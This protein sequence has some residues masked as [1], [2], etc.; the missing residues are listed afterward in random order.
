MR[1]W[2]GVT[3]QLW[4][5]QNYPAVTSDQMN[6]WDSN[7]EGAA[8]GDVPLGAAV[9][10]VCHWGYTGLWVCWAVP[11]PETQRLPVPVL[12]W[13]LHHATSASG[14]SGDNRLGPGGQAWPQGEQS[15]GSLRETQG[16]VHPLL[17]TIPPWGQAGG[18]VL[19][20]HWLQTCPSRWMLWRG[21]HWGCLTSPC[22]RAG[23][24]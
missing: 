8:Q 3:L 14:A 16:W 22:C 11:I 18:S 6:L 24:R 23:E 20:R 1:P 13:C 4:G 12:A 21:Q 7:P 2:A 17:S 10:A 19:T 9:L 15:V 5:A